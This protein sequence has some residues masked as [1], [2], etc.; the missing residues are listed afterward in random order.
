MEVCITILMRQNKELKV[1]LAKLETAQ[2]IKTMVNTAAVETKNNN[3][4]DE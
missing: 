3:V 4:K 1:N 2:K